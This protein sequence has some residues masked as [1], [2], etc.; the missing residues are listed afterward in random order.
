MIEEGTDE[1]AVQT[2]LDKFSAW[3]SQKLPEPPK[4]KENLQKFAK[5]HDR[6]CYQLIRFCFNPDSDYRTVVKALKEIKKRIGESTQLGILD[7]LTPLLYRVSQLI[8]N[9]SHVAPIVEFSRTDEFGLGATA[10]EV[11]K[12]MSGSNPAVFKANVKALSDLL[13]EQSPTSGSPDSTGA[14]DT[15]KACAG[16]AKSYPKDM[17]QERKLLQALVSFALTG[18]PPAAAKHAVT[19]L[20]HSANRKELYATDLVKRCIK[21]FQFGEEHFLAKLACLSQLALLAPDQCEDDQ[22]A[23]KELVTDIIVKVRTPKPNDENDE[24]SKSAW[25]ED[26]DLDDEIKAKLLALRVLVNRLRAHADVPTPGNAGV[27]KSLN[28]IVANEGEPLKTKNAPATH[29]SRLRLAAAQHLLKLATYR[30]YDDLITPVEFNRLAVVA[31][32]SC[33]QV[34]QGFINKLKK[35]LSS[36]KLNSRYYTIV[37]L[38][39]TET[40]ESWREEVVTWIRARGQQVSKAAN[41][42]GSNVMEGIFA[43]LMSLLVHHPDF[44]TQVK[45]LTDFSK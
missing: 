1:A 35:Y 4:A 33:L 9:K 29:R 20:M 6:R 27:V 3:L 24:D 8:Y 38:M 5:L 30:T 40:E 22:K 44:G 41:G 18:A 13:Q 15:L 21:D 31:Q 34:R 32:D 7:S 39:A 23:I 2:T 42:T 26:S 10:H 16:F 28:K 45:D 17:P 43:R 25:A 14:V 36:G 12:E 11:L 37:F 19:I